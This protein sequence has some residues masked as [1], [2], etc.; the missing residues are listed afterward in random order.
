V[1]GQGIKKVG[2]LGLLLAHRFQ[3]FGLAAALE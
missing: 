1:V 3:L 2:P